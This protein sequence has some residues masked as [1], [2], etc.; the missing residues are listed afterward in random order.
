MRYFKLRLTKPDGEQL[1]ETDFQVNLFD[2]FM[3]QIA[4]ALIRGKVLHEGEPYDARLIPRTDNRPIFDRIVEVKGAEINDNGQ[5]FL[6]ISFENGEPPLENITYITT[7]IR[8]AEKNTAYRYD[9]PLIKLIEMDSILR[10]S[11]LALLNEGTLKEG[12]HFRFALAAYDHGRARGDLEVVPK[13]A[14][15]LTHVFSPKNGGN[16]PK[17]AQKHPKPGENGNQI[18]SV[19]VLEQPSGSLPTPPAKPEEDLNIVVESVEELIKPELKAMSVYTNTETVG[20]ISDQDL[21]I[22]IRRGALAL[23]RKAAEH[24]GKVDE[25][26]GGFLVGKVFKDP[27]TEGLF[28]EVS[29]V[30][31]A[32]KA[33]GTY[34]S[35]NFSYE[36]WRQ[37][38]DRLDHEFRGKFPIGW[39][40]TH[41]VSSAIVTP[42]A[43]IEGE[44]SARYE[45]FFS[46]PDY[47][48]H[49]NF[50][51]DPWHVAMVLDL[52]CQREVF[53]AWRDGQI[54]KTQGF[55]VYGE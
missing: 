25:E 11:A 13:T 44:Y 27:A 40:H 1:F 32:D 4:S 17:P 21:P 16:V 30:V 9:Y 54:T 22:F 42:V 39:Y 2:F 3:R 19:V 23:A 37:V 38:L 49:R 36:A 46:E 12:D 52:R 34:V 10:N 29:E 18:P 28:V 20:S 50:F 5:G 55:Y 45:P 8:S 48:I 41:L 33:K 53:F 51:P 26:V 24:S 47:F 7:Q 15:E 31:E 6:D 43:E 14:Q 35:L